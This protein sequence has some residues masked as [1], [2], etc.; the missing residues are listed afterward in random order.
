MLLH[1]ATLTIF[2]ETSSYEAAMLLV[3]LAINYVLSYAMKC[4]PLFPIH[5]RSHCTFFH[6]EERPSFTQLKKTS[7]LYSANELYR[8]SDRRLSANLLTTFADRGVSR[9]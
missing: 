4:S 8:P 6:L 9:G 5:K 7:L 2:V 3:Y 1:V